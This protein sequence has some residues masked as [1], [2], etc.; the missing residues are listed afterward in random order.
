MSRR[1]KPAPKQKATITELANETPPVAKASHATG[2]ILDR[3]KKC[4][5][6]ANHVNANE[7]EA[8]AA[9]KIA[10]RLMSQHSVSQAELIDKE[11]PNERDERGGLSLVKITSSREG[12]RII[13]WTWAKD[14]A[15]AVATL[16]DCDAFS[17][18]SD[19]CLEWTFFGIAEHTVFAAMS[20]EMA[21]NLILDWADVFTTVQGRNSYCLG[22]ASGLDRL[23]RDERLHMENA[24][25]ENEQR[26]TAARMREGEL[27][28]LKAIARLNDQFSSQTKEESFLEDASEEKYEGFID[29]DDGS[30]HDGDD[31]TL[32][33]N[34]NYLEQHAVM[35]ELTGDFEADMAAVM[36][37]VK[38][39]LKQEQLKQEYDDDEDVDL[40]A[41]YRPASSSQ[42]PIKT[43]APVKLENECTPSLQW[44][45]RTQLARF[46]EN[47]AAIEEGVLRAQGIKL[48]KAKKRTRSVKDLAAYHK[49]KQD[50]K[51]IN[52]RVATIEDG[53]SST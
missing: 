52:M 19:Q 21:H 47:T 45:S 35:P 12:G 49:G 13:K 36:R 26:G 31:E 15:S 29:L 14:L 44:S 8:R 3:I 34:A 22:V 40:S 23:A 51:K 10:T 43:E 11:E 2:E 37:E 16:F 9:M 7:S 32:V 39:E 33:V 20:F 30:D 17:T 25:R 5:D 18:Q 48:K 4:L 6:R 24:V 38:S 53:R 1:A 42:A 46:R 27:E 28:R 41:L 50:S